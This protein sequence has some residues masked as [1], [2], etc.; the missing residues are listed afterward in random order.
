MQ[1]GFQVDIIPEEISARQIVFGLLCHT[2]TT[3]RAHGFA[4]R[5]DLSNGEIADILND[6]GILGWIEQPEDL[7]RF[8]SEEPLLMSWQVE[9]IGGALIPKLHIAGEEHL[10]PS[11]R[12]EPGMVMTTVA[13]TDSDIDSAIQGFLHPAVWQELL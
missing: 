9:H 10:Y 8:T 2:G 12:Y 13:G 3:P 6:T 4:V 11:L 7:A 1:V 5:V